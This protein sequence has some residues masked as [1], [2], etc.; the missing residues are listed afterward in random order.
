LQP[1]AD[2]SVQQT[3]PA[4]VTGPDCNRS[5]PINKT[6]TTNQTRLL[7]YLYKTFNLTYNCL[8]GSVR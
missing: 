5:K 2:I 8:R 1:K 3:C 6:A 4:T 7:E